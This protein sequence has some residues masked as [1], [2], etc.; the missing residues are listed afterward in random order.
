VELDSDLTF[1][2]NS[3]NQ[4]HYVTFGAINIPE[5]DW[6]GGE[7]GEVNNWFNPNNWASRSIPDAG[8]NITIGVKA[9][10]PIVDGSDIAFVNDLEISNGATLTLKPGSRMTVNGDI[11]TNNNNLIIENTVTLPS[12]FINFGAVADA[13]SAADGNILIKWQYPELRW[14]YLGLPVTEFT[15]GDFGTLSGIGKDAIVY[16]HASRWVGP[17]TDPTVKFD[18]PMT[19]YGLVVKAGNENIDYPGTLNNNSSYSKTLVNGWQ[20]IAN[21]YPS[22]YNLQGA[23]ADFAN[24]T[25]SIYGYTGPTATRTVYTYNV[26]SGIGSGTNHLLAPSQGFWVK[27]DKNG[28]VFMRQNRR[29]HNPAKTGLKSASGDESDLL[30]IK[31]NNGKAEDE[32]VIAFRSNGSD[33]FNRMDSEKK[34]DYGKDVSGIYSY[35]SETKAVINALAEGYAGSSV[36]LGYKPVGGEK[37]YL[38]IEGINGLTESVDVV[39]EDTYLK[40]KTLM[41]EGGVY[42]FDAS[43]EEEQS[44]KRFILKFETKNDVPTGIDDQKAENSINVFVTDG[45]SVNINCDW[46]VNEKQV[47]IYNITGRLILNDTFTGQN[48]IKNTVFKAGIYIVNVT[49][50]DEVYEEKIVIK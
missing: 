10:D 21:P 26:E 44:E 22:Y 36:Q 43:T 39:L 47:R 37:H 23:M 42:S 20:M 5:Y 19:G 46:T 14:W 50:V 41:T 35:A 25:G 11:T 33:L 7:P 1:G 6:V 3:S 9:N 2:F 29:I 27:K 15:L 17:Y 4:N 32:T 16:T 49:G 40:S 8:T 30:R 45:S 31:L 28:D 13:T 48:Y 12:S 38:Q 24:T 34:M 18:T